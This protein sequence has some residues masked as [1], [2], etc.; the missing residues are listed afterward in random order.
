ML[1]VELVTWWYGQGWLT[2]LRNM[3]RRLLRTSQLFS[4]PSLLRTLFAPWRRIMTY[5]GEGLE[6]HVRAATDNLVS[7]MVGFVVRIIVLITACIIMFVVML[8]ALIELIAWP[9]LPL[10]ILVSLIKGLIG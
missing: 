6:E 2:L 5:P 7:R 10:G 3:Q 9:L 4:L 8:V 1:A